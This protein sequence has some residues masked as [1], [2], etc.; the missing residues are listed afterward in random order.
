[1]AAKPEDFARIYA[2]FQAPIARFDCGKKCAPINGG[3]P[4]CC[5]TQHAVP[6]VQKSE[7]RLLKSRTDLWRL[8]KPYD[9]PTRKIVHG[10]HRT[11]TA[12]E[13][14]GVAFC[15]RENRSMACRAFPFYPYITREGDFIGL[16]YYWEFE[17]SCWVISNLSVVDAGFIREFVAAHETLF[18]ADRDE[19]DTFRQQSASMRRLF[20]RRKRVIPLIGRDGGFFKVMPKSGRVL[21]ADPARFPK[22]GPYKSARAYA[23]AVDAA[24]PATE[25]RSIEFA[26]DPAL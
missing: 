18:A 26:P 22:H 2:R 23:R 8:F 3:E 21:L 10:L 24:G 19:F 20:S 4:V 9:G 17:D 16:A 15:E 7:W 5:S 6:L 25:E 14:K 1:M 13:C 12:I 11:C